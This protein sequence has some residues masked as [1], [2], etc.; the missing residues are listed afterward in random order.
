M[1]AGTHAG[2]SEEA[3][4]SRAMSAQWWMLREMAE[5]LADSGSAFTAAS[6]RADASARKDGRPK[7]PAVAATYP[8]QP[9]PW[10]RLGMGEAI[11]S[12]A[13]NADASASRSCSNAMRVQSATRP[14]SFRH[15]G[16]PGFRTRLLS[17]SRRA[18]DLAAATSAT[19]GMTA[20]PPVPERGAP[21]T[22]PRGRPARS[23]LRAVE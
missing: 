11:R 8:G 12:K 19:A 10:V 2:G 13:R 18:N 14:G 5:S 15:A 20:L 21:A 22:R 23:L 6:R 7:K 9:G 16:S 4:P 1:R 3:P 17:S